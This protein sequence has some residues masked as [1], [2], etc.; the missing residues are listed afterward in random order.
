MAKL[1]KSGLKKI[2][3]ECL[4]EILSEGISP[5]LIKESSTK[6]VS[7]A[8]V[9]EQKRLTEHR[10]K[11]EHHVEDTIS[12]ITNDSV[13]ADIF[14]DTAT[15][16]LQEQQENNSSLVDPARSTGVDLGQLFGNASTNWEELAFEK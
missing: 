13:M 4:V 2:V 7:V 14:R 6:Q 12:G 15:T 1:T 9:A 10:Q 16:T 8:R 5:E 11:F 3:K